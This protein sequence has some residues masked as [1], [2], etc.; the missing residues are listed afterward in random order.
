MLAQLTQF[1][2]DRRGLPGVAARPLGATE[3]CHSG[4]GHEGDVLPCFVSRGAEKKGPQ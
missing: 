4:V 3:G 1:Q 2:G